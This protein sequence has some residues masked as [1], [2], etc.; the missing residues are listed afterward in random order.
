MDCFIGFIVICIGLVGLLYFLDQLGKPR[1]ERQPLGKYE[2][3]ELDIKPAE[4]KEIKYKIVTNWKKVNIGRIVL[5]YHT[6]SGDV[7]TKEFKGT[8]GL[9][10]FYVDLTNK[11][12]AYK[13]TINEH[14]QV[15]C[16]YWIDPVDLISILN[17]ENFKEYHTFE[18]KVLISEFNE[19]KF[20]N[21]KVSISKDEIKK[22]EAIEYHELVEVRYDEVKPL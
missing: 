20:N 8:T 18:C 14:I 16:N 15:C 12:F 5:N 19:D 9:H 2:I 11:S 6:K 13:K 7:Y 10:T 21:E 3:K 1:V 17:N 4:V 22:I